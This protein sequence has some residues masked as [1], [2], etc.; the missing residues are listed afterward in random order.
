MKK[1]DGQDLLIQDIQDQA[2]RSDEAGAAMKA[3]LDRL[4]GLLSRFDEADQDAVE[5]T[6]KP[7]FRRFICLYQ[8]ALMLQECDEEN[9]E[10]MEPALRYML[11]RL[12][13]LPERPVPAPGAGTVESKIAWQPQ[14]CRRIIGCN[15]VLC[16]PAGMEFDIIELEYY[17]C[18]K[19]HA[20]A[21]GRCLE[22]SK[23][24]P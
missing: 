16:R 4:T 8:M 9:V 22:P 2:G 18:C 19:P 12:A 6:A 5:T 14:G 11:D 1:S 21:L 17:R 7:L 3:E 10:W 13:G 23:R 15:S 20:T 24:E